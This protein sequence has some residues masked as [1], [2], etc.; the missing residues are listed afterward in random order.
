MAFAHEHHVIH[1]DLKLTNLLINN[2]GILKIAD[3]GLARE[4]G[5][6]RF[7]MCRNTLQAINKE[8]GYVVVSG[9]WVVDE[10][11]RLRPWGRHMVYWL[12]HRWTAPKRSTPVPGQR[13][14]APVQADLLIDRLP[15]PRAVA[16]VLWLI[17]Q[18]V[19]K[20]SLKVCG[21]Q[22]EQPETLLQGVLEQL[23]RS[24][25][26]DNLLEQKETNSTPGSALP[27]VFL[28]VP[29]KCVSGRDQ[30]LE[31]SGILC[32]EDHLITG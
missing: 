1:R 11:Q 21:A 4:F 29:Q 5:N 15:N 12:H 7:H 30:G 16:R 8:G 10:N 18:I 23:H 27:P 20:I 14:T 6:F 3:F 28:W 2:K 26:K 32:Q 17:K 24:D 13:L 31:Q 9:T 19:Q 22:D 25:R